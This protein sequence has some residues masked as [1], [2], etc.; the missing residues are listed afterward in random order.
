MGSLTKRRRTTF[1]VQCVH[2]LGVDFNMR[3]NCFS[4]DLAK[5]LDAHQ[6]LVIENGRLVED[7][8][9]RKLTLDDGRYF[10]LWLKENNSSRDNTLCGTKFFSRDARSSLPEQP[11][12]VAG[13]RASLAGDDRPFMTAPST[14]QHVKEVHYMIQHWRIGESNG[15]QGSRLNPIAPTFTPKAPTPSQAAARKR[16]ETSTEDSV[17]GTVSK[18]ASSQTSRQWSDE[19]E[20]KA[21]HGDD[22]VQSQTISDGKTNDG[23]GGVV[24]SQCQKK[25]EAVSPAHILSESEAQIAGGGAQQTPSRSTTRCWEAN[26]TNLPQPL[27]LSLV[28][29]WLMRAWIKSP[30][31]K[32]R[33]SSARDILVVFSPKV[34]QPTRRRARSLNKD[35]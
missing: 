28:D 13:H 23:L 9:P 34:N 21:D 33:N 22:I 35:R 17:P 24:I 7:G 14:P 10:A 26:N 12:Q 15:L 2:S 19:L 16:N 5:S 20:E 27:L 30:N 29:H 8:A 18:P 32:T 31:W 11:I 3:P 1:I 4:R 6:I 25:D